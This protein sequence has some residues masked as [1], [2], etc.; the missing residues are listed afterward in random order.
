MDIRSLMPDRAGE[1]SDRMDGPAAV[2]QFLR[3]VSLVDLVVELVQNEL[4][5]GASRTIIEFGEHGLIC[6]GNG[7]KLNRK[8][9]AR[10]E[11]VIGAGGEI[12]AKRGGIGS[13]NHGLRTLFLLSDRIGVQSDGLRTD[14]TPSGET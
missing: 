11:S 5:A 8:D 3:E 14:L 13:K 7:E 6:Q 1:P 2:G 12:Q 9:W 4:D 10:L